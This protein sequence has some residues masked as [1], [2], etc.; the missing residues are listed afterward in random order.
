MSWPLRSFPLFLLYGASAF[1]LYILC[2]IPSIVEK[3]SYSLAAID[4]SPLYT[5]GKGTSDGFILPSFSSTFDGGDEESDNGGSYSSTISSPDCHTDINLNKTYC[6]AKSWDDNLDEWWQHHPDWDISRETDDTYCFSPMA[7]PERAKF[8]RETVYPLQWQ[9]K[10]CNEE[11]SDLEDSENSCFA[12]HVINSGY[13]ANLGLLGISF[14]TAIFRNHSAFC[15]SKRYPDQRWLYSNQ[16]NANG[17][18]TPICESGDMECYFLP[19]TNCHAKVK[20]HDGYDMD[21][22]KQHGSRF[23]A[24]HITWLRQYLTRPQLWLRHEIYK[25]RKPFLQRLRQSSSCTVIHVRRTDVLLEGN[26]RKRRH[27]FA[28]DDYLH[29]TRRYP[30]IADKN[31]LLLTDDQSTI[32]E[33]HKYHN[34]TESQWTYLPRFRWRG[35]EGGMNGHLP[36][37]D[38]KKEIIILLTELS[39]AGHCNRLIHGKSGF[40]QLIKQYMR[41]GNGTEDVYHKS[42]TDF[43]IGT[44]SKPNATYTISEQEFFSRLEKRHNTEPVK[45]R[46]KRKKK[47]RLRE[48]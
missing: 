41:V 9:S 45:R 27:Y 18:G 43:D 47:K 12:H 34:G 30:D 26:W 44:R 40:S 38:V 33:L 21:I 46:E 11:Q 2:K 29:V 22:V 8:L 17:T 5:T 37:G 7:N 14:M 19:I 36:S 24:P 20:Q 6:C 16:R 35:T 39:L 28:L 10:E 3:H 31:I 32:D 42:I 1:V 4:D 15:L 48:N 23:D 13:S 25:L